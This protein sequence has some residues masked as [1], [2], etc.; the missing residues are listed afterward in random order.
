LAEKIYTDTLKDTTRW[1]RRFAGLKEKFKKRPA[2]Q[3]EAK[4]L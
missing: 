4:K 3:R 1:E 2:F